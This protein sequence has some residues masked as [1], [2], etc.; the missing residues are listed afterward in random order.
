M[1]EYALAA[2]LVAAVQ[3]ALAG[4]EVE[5]VKEVHLR[6][7]ELRLVVDEALQQ[8]YRLLTAG[9]PLEG[10]ELR[11]EEVKVELGCRSCGYRGPAEYE[12]AAPIL[13]CPRCG[14]GVELLRGR[15]LEL[16]RVTVALPGAVG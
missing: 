5:R 4:R 7:G 13:E 6:K 8:A 9:T 3:R 10:S 1:H 12:C 15:E 14:A 11:I 2:E 16:T